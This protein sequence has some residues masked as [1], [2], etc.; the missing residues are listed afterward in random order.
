MMARA[1]QDDPYYLYTLP[2]ESRRRRLL[3]W[4]MERLISFGLCYGKVFTTAAIE[5]A[6]VWLGPRNPAF[7][8]F[9][10]IRT[11][12]ALMRLKLSPPEWKRIQLLERAE[13]QLHAYAVQGAHWY[14]PVLGVE[15]ACQG[16]GIGGTLLQPVLDLADRDHLVCYLETNNA[17]NLAFY[18]NFGFQPAGQEQPDPEGPTVWGMLRKAE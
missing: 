5:G 2:D 1:F 8:G 10:A 9:G 6:A 16:R 4:L 15:P 17:R 3:P 11:G 18:E 13:D 7:H 14:L 12:L